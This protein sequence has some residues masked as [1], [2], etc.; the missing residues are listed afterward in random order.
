MNILHDN[1]YKSVNYQFNGLPDKSIFLAIEIIK[2][3]KN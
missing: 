2:I 3:I 1:H